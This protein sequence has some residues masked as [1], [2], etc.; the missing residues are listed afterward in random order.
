MDPIT[1]IYQRQIAILSESAAFTSLVKISPNTLVD[2]SDPKFFDSLEQLS[3]ADTPRVV[4]GQSRFGAELFG[5]AS[6]T[7]DFNQT[8]QYVLVSADLRIELLNKLK[9]I[10]LAA[11]TSAGDSLGLDG[12]VRMWGI[13]SVMDV[14]AAGNTGSKRWMSYL[15]ITVDFYMSWQDFAAMGK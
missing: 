14:A 10:T 7:A 2:M 4:I 9:F 11:L 12:V 1:R 13:G 6:R 8:F 3:L 5:K 15:P